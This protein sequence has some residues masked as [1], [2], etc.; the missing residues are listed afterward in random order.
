[1]LL[2]YTVTLHENIGDKFT[3]VFECL[4]EDHDHAE[5]QATNAYPNADIIFVYNEIF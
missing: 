3:I 2:P 1:M 4:A 5:E